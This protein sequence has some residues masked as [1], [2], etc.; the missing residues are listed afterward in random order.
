MA[1]KYPTN[2]PSDKSKKRRADDLLTV[3]DDDENDASFPRFLV[4]EPS[5][6][7]QIK[8]SIFAIQKILQCA[9]GAVKSAKKLRSGSVLI[10][11]QTKAQADNA[12]AMQMWIDTPV[13]VSAHRSLNVSRGV[14]R[15]R[16]F[17]DCSDT[18]ILDALRSQGVTT[19]KHIVSKR[20]GNPEP[21][22]TIILTFNT[23]DAP[24]FVKAAYQKIPVETFIPNP[25]RCFNCQKFG[26]GKNT[27][28]RHAVCA[29]CGKEGHQDSEC[30]DP[31]HCANCAGD[32]PVYSRDCPEWLKQK[33]ITTVKFQQ[34]ISFREARQVVEQRTA[35]V[36]GYCATTGGRRAGTTYAQA[37]RTQRAVSTQTDLTWP[38]DAKSPTWVPIDASVPMT[39]VSETQTDTHA[40]VSSGAIP[41]KPPIPRK[42]SDPKRSPTPTNNTTGSKQ[43][44]IRHDNK[45]TVQSDPSPGPSCSK[46]KPSNRESKG[47]LDPLR[48]YNKYGTLDDCDDGDME[49][50][51]PSG[52][53]SHPSSRK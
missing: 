33:D 16:D 5:T 10:E 7:E 2:T 52:S 20:N 45:K 36:N 31:P 51:R 9:V 34:G 43:P 23:P 17:R 26:H 42:P 25:L 30:H 3:S 8:H 46:N 14:I 12:M 40:D 38:F 47:S 6:E 15:C 1:E 24:K 32:H 49:C 22:N 4:V 19:V 48:S 37:A 44:G 35:N 29:R 11:V 28:S 21:T 53:G 27:C 13:K 39:T 50:D 18:E 41:K